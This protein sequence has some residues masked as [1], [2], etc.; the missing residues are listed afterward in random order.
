MTCY[1][2]TC[3]AGLT[4]GH[5]RKDAFAPDEAIANRREA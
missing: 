1:S 3:I 5:A 2:S 4:P